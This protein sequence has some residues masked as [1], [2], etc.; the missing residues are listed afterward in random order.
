[1][2]GSIGDGAR[3]NHILEC[4]KEIETSIEGYTLETFSHSGWK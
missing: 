4:I 1:M 2:K 3:I